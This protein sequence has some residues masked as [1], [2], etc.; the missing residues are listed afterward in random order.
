MIWSRVGLLLVVVAARAGAQLPDVPTP[1]TLGAN[2]NAD[3]VGTGTLSDYDF[4]EGHWT[5]RFQTRRGDGKFNPTV[6]GTWDARKVHEGRVAEDEFSLISASN[7]QRSLTLTYRVF[8][9]NKKSWQM[10]GI[11]LTNPGFWGNGET[12]SDAQNRYAIQHFGQG[13]VRIRYYA[14]TANHFLWRADG[15][16]DGGKTWLRDYWRLEATRVKG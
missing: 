6:A 8:N 3:S 14:I 10:T 15:S 4:L 11:S 9:P 1:D 13:M 5:I 16:N 2:F 7:G 12:W